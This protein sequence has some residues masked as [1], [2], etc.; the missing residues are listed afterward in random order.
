M[1][2]APITR[3]PRWTWIAP[4]LAVVFYAIA[5]AF[6]FAAHLAPG[7]AGIALAV[8]L[9]P[10]LFGAIFAAVYHAEVI[11]HRAGEPYGTLILTAAVTIIE[12][13]LI[14]SVMIPEGLVKLTSRASG[15]SSSISRQRS[16]ATGMVRRAFMKPPGPVV[17]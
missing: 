16:R 5:A 6:G 4:L 11:A 9:F 8:L 13:A 15:A 14:A 12:V 17:S 7:A 10:A 2:R 1:T 3:M